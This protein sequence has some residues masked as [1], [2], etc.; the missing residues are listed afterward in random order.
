MTAQV[1]MIRHLIRNERQVQADFGGLVFPDHEPPLVAHG[2]LIPELRRALSLSD[3]V[4]VETKK[5]KPGS[6][7]VEIKGVI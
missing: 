4:S 3:I 7:F 1:P 5:H 2:K 6:R